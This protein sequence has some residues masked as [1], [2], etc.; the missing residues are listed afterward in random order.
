MENG[1]D[2][3]INSFQYGFWSMFKWKMETINSFSIWVLFVFSIAKQMDSQNPKL[4]SREK[5]EHPWW[6]AKPKERIAHPKT[7]PN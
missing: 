6:W 5:N 7:E 2:Y 4:V 3:I 1:N